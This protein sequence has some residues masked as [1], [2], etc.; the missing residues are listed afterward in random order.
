MNRAEYLKKYRKSA[1]WK[2]YFNEWMRKYRK[3]EKFKKYNR[4]YYQKLKLRGYIKEYCARPEVVAKRKKYDAK[5]EHKIRRQIYS[6]TPEGIASR[7]K[8]AR[9]PLGRLY[10]KS[11]KSNRKI[12]LKVVQLVYDS[13]VKKYGRLTCYLCFLPIDFGND[14]LEHKTPISR[15]GGNTFE[16]LD[17]SCAGCNR[18]KH[19]KTA[20]EFLQC[21]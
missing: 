10:Y 4:E 2:K 19:T 18:R 6:R 1:K 17:V 11:Q 8:W 7:I 16:N 15:G 13:N 14:H 9:S 3:T 12:G 20:E 5:P 21:V